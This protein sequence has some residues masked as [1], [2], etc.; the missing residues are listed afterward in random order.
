MTSPLFA[1][2]AR[3]ISRSSLADAAVLETAAHGTVITR[4]TF[5][6]REVSRSRFDGDVE[7][8]DAEPWAVIPEADAPDVAKGDLIYVSG[9]LWAVRTPL[10]DG[11][12]SVKLQLEVP[13]LTEGLAIIE[14]DRD[15]D[16][17]V[18]L[19]P[20]GSAPA[21]GDEIDG[22][23]IVDGVTAWGSGYAKVGLTRA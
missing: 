1:V 22:T 4:A 20:F 15:A 19:A 14:V 16:T 10:D 3:T 13:S 9:R 23:W 8:L 7:V 6:R 12:A 2:L 11:A 5:Q 18:A 17:T 21:V